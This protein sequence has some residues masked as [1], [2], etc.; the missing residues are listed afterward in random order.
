MPEKTS[1]K[2]L[3]ASLHLKVARG[4]SWQM[5]NAGTMSN[6]SG[7]QGNLHIKKIKMELISYFSRGKCGT[8]PSIARE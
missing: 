7:F 3:S 1:E 5:K 2:K 4:T 6:K 8:C